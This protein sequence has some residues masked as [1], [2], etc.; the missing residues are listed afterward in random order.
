M[1]HQISLAKKKV[2][3]ITAIINDIEEEAIQGDYIVAFEPIKLCI[4]HLDELYLQYG[5]NEESQAA[6]NIYTKL[7][8]AFESEYEI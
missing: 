2:E 6:M 8:T 5:I 4:K 3:L 1:E 7:I